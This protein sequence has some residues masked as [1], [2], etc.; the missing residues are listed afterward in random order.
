MLYKAALRAELTVRCGVSWT[1]VDLPAEP[2]ERP[3]ELGSRHPPQRR[4]GVTETAD[5]AR[6][7][8]RTP[9]RHDEP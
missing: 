9:T 8:A 2:F 5:V 3:N 4:H 1:F 6:P 7:R